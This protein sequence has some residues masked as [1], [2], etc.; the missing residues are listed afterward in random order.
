M[1]RVHVLAS[2]FMLLLGASVSSAQ[3]DRP[4]T[5][6]EPFP[7][8][9]EA[10]TVPA[11]DGAAHTLG[12]TITL[13]D[14]AVW[15]AG[16]YPGVVLVTGSGPQDRDETIFRHK[17]F[18]VLADHLTRRG[19]AVLRYDDRGVGESTGS[20]ASATVTGLAD[21]AHAAW[22]YLR[23]HEATDPERVGIAGH[24]EGGMIAPMVASGNPDVAFLVLMAGTGVPGAEVLLF[25]SESMFAAGGLDEAW[26]ARSTENRAA[27]FELVREGAGDDAVL[28]GVVRVLTHEMPHVRDAGALRRIAEQALPQ[29]AGSWAREFITLDPRD[30]LR[31]VSVPV[32]ALNGSLD[33]QVTIDQNLAQI[34]IA[35]GEGACPSFTSVR[36]DG[37]NH[38]FQP[39][40]TGML[41]EYATIETTFDEHALGVISGW[42][43][44]T[45]GVGP[46]ERQP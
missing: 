28:E 18:M 3:P 41:G 37:L 30:Y 39:A 24:S 43:A 32:L 34:E 4:Q 19:I 20:F 44:A 21:D 1:H 10:A 33:T 38:L 15:G 9:V 14:S 13:P 26:I 23:D 6:A 2:A 7:Y 8:R 45:T 42:V 35:L 36:L 25:Q 22:R 16:P 12:A 11:G 40:T 17:P 31:K 5:P 29:F 46:P 27:V